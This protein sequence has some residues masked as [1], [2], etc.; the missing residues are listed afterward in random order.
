MISKLPVDFAEILEPE[1]AKLLTKGNYG[2]IWTCTLNDG[3]SQRKREIEVWRRL[4]HPNIVP[5]LGL[6]SDFGCKLPPDVILP[7]MVSPY[8]SKG[9]LHDY[10]RVNHLSSLER[11]R[12]L[13]NII[14]GLLFLHSHGIIHGDLRPSN[15]LIDDRQQACLIDFGLSLIEGELEGTPR[16]P[17]T[18]GAVRWRAPE[19]VPFAECQT[20]NF[21]PRLTKACDIYSFGGVALQ[22]IADTVPYE[23]IANTQLVLMQLMIRRLPIRPHSP[24]LTDTLWLFIQRCWGSVPTARLTAVEVKGELADF[25][26]QERETMLTASL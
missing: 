14:E 11:L 21:Q 19:L 5:L 15:V 4:I 2:E 23:E 13:Q 9:N 8:L 16:W 24:M 7:G 10:L 26:E 22:T 12:I 17:Q 6:T 20:T 1:N 3:T 18:F 25:V